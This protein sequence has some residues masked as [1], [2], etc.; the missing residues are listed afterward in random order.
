[1]KKI[2]VFLLS[3]LVFV[4]NILAQNIGNYTS[5][6]SKNG[7]TFSFN[8]TKGKVKITFCTPGMYRIQTSWGKGF[9]A[10]EPWMVV[11]Y[12]WDNFPVNQTEDTQSFIFETS[13]LKVK[14]VKENF[15]ISTFNKQGEMLSSDVAVMPMAQ[16]GDT[17]KCT[18]T[19]APDEHFFGFGERMDFID[20]RNKKLTLN[21]GRGNELPYIIGAYNVLE[22]NYCPVPFFMSTK[23][24]G[25]FL[26]NS[27]ATNWDMGNRNQ[28]QY[29]FSAVD[30]ELDYYFINGPKFQNI[31]QQYTL[32]TGRAPLM[33][34]FALGLH[35]GTYAGGTWGYET[36]TSDLYVVMLA[37]K[38]RKMGIN[39]DILHIDSV[40]R[41]FGK[42]GGKGATTYEWRPTFRNPK[43][44]FDSIYAMHY[45]MVSLHMRPRLDNGE[46]YN[47]LQQAQALGFTYPENGKPGEFIN[48]FDQKSVDWWW[49]NG[50]TKVAGIGAKFFKTDEGSA[51][52]SLANESDKVGPTGKEA[53]RL[54]NL[55]PIAYAKAPYEKFQQL[56]GS[57]G[58][59]LTREGYA[60]IQRYPYIFAG[61]WPSEWQYFPAVIKAGINI[62]LSGVGNWGHCMGGFEHNADPELYIRWCEFGFFSPIAHLFGMDHP[63]YKEPWNY[64]D[65]A[66]RIFKKYDS[67][68]YS[69]IPY[70]YATNYQMHETGLPIM[71]ALV[72]DNQNDPNTYDIADQY[73]LGNSLLVCPVTV[74][75]AVTRSVYLP[76]GDWYNYWTGK[77]Y[78]GKQYVHV[79]TPLDTMPIFAKAGSI[80]P[81]QP[82]M[83]YLGEKKVDAITLDIFPG[84]S[85]SAQLY[86]DDGLSLDYQKGFFSTTNI[87]SSMEGNTLKLNISKPSGAFVPATHGYLAKIHLDKKPSSITEN[88]SSLNSFSEADTATKNGWY[89]D[90]SSKILWVKMNGNNKNEI[91]LTVNL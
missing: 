2:L 25:I 32:L 60:G 22:A 91:K 63:G 9:E 68:R 49:Q 7:N 8:T 15:S 56:N 38:L 28:S 90:E 77:K 64:G 3:F 26:H 57:R 47:L 40:W 75:G 44:M 74:K 62:G 19:L 11:K 67:L 23:G 12:D 52:G 46:K 30:G 73:M 54:H 43:A 65:E 76:E 48:F 83:A 41:L 27:F 6:F 18:K 50:A 80:I 20:Q 13:E 1:M 39:V 79:V 36:M 17:V 35:V 88:A 55:F 42:E 85:G 4:V 34:Q 53:Q 72:L 24:Y 21:V 84:A 14:V 70:L 87:V 33:P 82:S 71:R 69:L 89:F 61:D 5:G 78:S 51:F 31:L 59:N 58:M 37:E 86:E 66:L 81:M 45:K 29:S 16:N 10:D